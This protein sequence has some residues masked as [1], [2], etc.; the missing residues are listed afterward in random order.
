M[1]VEA[2]AFLLI[3]LFVYAGT[4]KLF[5]WRLFQFQ[6]QS[7]PWIRLFSEW[8]VWGVPALELGIAILLTSGRGRLIGFYASFVL[9]VVFT[10]YLLLMLGTQ[11][12]LPCACGG[13]IQGLSWGQHVLFNLF[14]IALALAGI[15][16][17]K[18]NHRKW[19]EIFSHHLK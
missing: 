7:Y 6:L 9:L 8:V 5:Q 15:L 10:V 3:L 17:G 1:T 14:F 2:C 18:K 19:N 16:C 12:H 4:N 11:Q 13:V